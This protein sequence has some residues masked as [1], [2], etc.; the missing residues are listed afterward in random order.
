MYCSPT[1][2]KRMAADRLKERRLAEKR[3]DV[4][5]LRRGACYEAIMRE[6][7]LGR[8]YLEDWLD[9]DIISDD[10]VAQQVAMSPSV[11]S[12][13]KAAI[14]IDRELMAEAARFELEKSPR[15]M[16]GPSH[17][18]MVQLAKEDP[19]GFER[20]LDRAVDAFVAWRH[21]Y[22]HLGP[23]KPYLTKQ[24]HRGWIRLTLKVIYTG[25]R[26]MILSP[27]RHGKSELMVHFSVW[28]ILR[29]PDIRILWIG[30]NQEI[31]ENMLGLVRSQL[32]ENEVLLRDYLPPGETWK[33]T[34]RGSLW[35]RQKFTVSQ[36]DY[37]IKQP[38]MWCVGVGGR[39]LSMD[40]DLIFVDDPDDPDKAMTEGGR[41]K[42]LYWFK[43][44]LATRKMMHT[45]LMMISSRV[46]MLDLYSHYVDDTSTWEIQVDKAHN[47]GICGRPIED[48]HDPAD[49][50]CILFPEINPWEYLIEQLNTVGKA[51]FEMIYLN[52]PRP[53]SILI[54]H[55]DDIRDNALDH[56]RD[57]GTDDIPERVRLI[58]GLDPA[59][60]ATQAAFQWGFGDETGMVYMVDSQTQEAGGIEGAIR[61][62]REWYTRYGNDIW[63]IEDNGYQKTFFDDPRIKAL[64]IELGLTIQ[65]THT[66][67][68]KRDPDF[69]VSA[70]AAD[71]H[72]GRINL[73]YR[74]PE[75]QRKVDA[76]I[77]ELT[78]FTT[79]AKKQRRNKSDILM[80]QWFPWS[81]VIKRWR[82]EMGGHRLHVKPNYHQSYSSLRTLS[83]N[84]HA[85]WGSTKYPGG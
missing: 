56:T 4:G 25:G 57:I 84:A 64:E 37:R 66:G 85:P 54:F 71:Y 41:E 36:Q 29:N 62:M 6:V 59:S 75:A 80:A 83:P 22:M 72:E 81:R 44:K 46:H 65:P 50:D 34:A 74:T 9:S 26:G 53:D 79:E 13:T 15:R 3:T 1:C 19:E 68:N 20:A 23:N 2:K 35:A 21:K 18:E 7:K 14:I 5:S 40:C 51:L 61:V 63:I 8:L 48:Y 69:G 24:F 55:P 49:N 16:L 43:V 33:P 58:A 10:E 45:G 77:K 42:T 32:E 60:R 17:A 76:L 82:K 31:A 70:M 12:R 39:I 78:V 47:Q 67:K 73:P 27:P 28:A 38:T 52:Q 11:V 30:P